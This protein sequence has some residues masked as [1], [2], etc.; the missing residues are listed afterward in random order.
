MSAV[1][2]HLHVVRTSPAER[3]AVSNAPGDVGLTFTILV[4]SAL[5]LVSMIAGVGRWGDASPYRNAAP[6]PPQRGRSLSPAT[7][8]FPVPRNADALSLAKRG[9]PLPR[10]EP[11]E[12]VGVRGARP[13]SA[14]R[15]APPRTPGWL[16]GP[17]L[18]P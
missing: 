9:L 17:G 14:D 7:R 15:R 18:L 8:P 6:S 10:Q 5:P 3:E 11:G 2:R 1:E 16:L 13:R 4:V 12:R